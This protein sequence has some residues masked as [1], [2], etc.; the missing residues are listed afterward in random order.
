MSLAIHFQTGN[1]S[2]YKEVS[3]FVGTDVIKDILYIH[4]NTGDSSVDCKDFSELLIAVLHQNILHISDVK[5]S[6]PLEPMKPSERQSEFQAFRGL[7]LFGELVDRCVTYSK[8]HNLDRICL[9]AAHISLVPFFEKYGFVVDD[10]PTGKLGM[11]HGS[12][13]PMT[14][15]V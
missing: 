2:L 10:T 13:I 3:N 14:R 4:T 5:F 9:T 7:N 12:S 15:L 8:E 11:A 6:N 1:P